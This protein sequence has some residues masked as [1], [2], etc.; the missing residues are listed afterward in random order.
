VRPK[1]RAGLRTLKRRLGQED[2]PDGD[3]DGALSVE[4]DPDPFFSA[5][6][7]DALV[8]AVVR[9]PDEAC[10]GDLDREVLQTSRMLQVHHVLKFLVLKLRLKESAWTSFRLSLRAVEASAGKPQPPPSLML[11]LT[12]DA[13]ANEYLS[14]DRQLVLEYRL[15]NGFSY[16]DVQQEPPAMGLPVQHDTDGIGT[17]AHEDEHSGPKY[18]DGGTPPSGALSPRSSAPLLTEQMPLSSHAPTLPAPVDVAPVAVA[19]TLEA[20]YFKMLD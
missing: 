13:I 16:A 4:P 10:L 17:E 14:D 18:E 20:D 7:E 2:A 8:F 15:A 5:D 1:H 11:D 19:P 6:Q 9:H 12:L 3:G